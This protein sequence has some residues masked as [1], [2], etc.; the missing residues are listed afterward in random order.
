MQYWHTGAIWALLT[1][2]AFIQFWLAISGGLPLKP[3]NFSGCWIL[4]FGSVAIAHTGIL[5]TWVGGSSCSL[6]ASL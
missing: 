1:M 3:V 4:Q 5:Q 6:V 2:D